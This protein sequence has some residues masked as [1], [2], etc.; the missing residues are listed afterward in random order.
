MCPSDGT[1]RCDRRDTSV[2]EPQSNVHD[3]KIPA[4]LKNGK[5]FKPLNLVN[6]NAQGLTN[7]Y[8]FLKEL[9]ESQDV[10]ICC[11]TET[12]TD[13]SVNDSEFL[14]DGYTCYRS[15][16]KLEYYTEGTFTS[17][18]RG[19]AAIVVKSSLNPTPADDINP[20]AEF[21]VCVIEPV[22]GKQILIGS[23]YRPEKGK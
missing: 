22:P 18:Y 15:D 4:N 7:K 14:P 17:I 20:E 3:K 9:L 21:A 10:D 23:V 8:I 19:G 1:T 13:D 2:E 6:M 16:R 11:I 12:W 5:E